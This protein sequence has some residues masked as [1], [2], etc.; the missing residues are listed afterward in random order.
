MNN[1]NN[2]IRTNKKKDII[3]II[4]VDIKLF[5]IFGLLNFSKTGNI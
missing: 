3:I 2:K 1:K 5:F 4:L